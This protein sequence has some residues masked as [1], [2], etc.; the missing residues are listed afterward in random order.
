MSFDADYTHRLTE[1]V[2]FPTV[3]AVSNI[4]LV[5]HVEALA[6]ACGARPRRFEEAG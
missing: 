5:E 1:L 3:S 4:A 6:T 2:A